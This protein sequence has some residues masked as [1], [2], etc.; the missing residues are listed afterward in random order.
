WYDTKYGKAPYKE[1]LRVTFNFEGINEE[2]IAYKQYQLLLN[3]DIVQ[4]H[5]E[6]ATGEGIALFVPGTNP[7]Q[8]FKAEGIKYKILDRKVISYEEVLASN[9]MFV[10]SK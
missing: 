3:D 4:A 8:V 9:N 1:V 7:E 2:D 6:R 10:N 5:M